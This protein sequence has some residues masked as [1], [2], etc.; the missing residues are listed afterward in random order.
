MSTIET[1]R[2]QLV[3]ASAVT[4]LVGQ[5]IYPQVLPPDMNT[6]PAVTLTLVSEVPVNSL[7][8]AAANRLKVARVQ[9]DVFAKTYREAHAAF[10][11]IDA[12][13]ADLSSPTLSAYGESSQDSYDDETQRHGVSG[14]Y[15]VS[16]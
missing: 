12:V 8:G 2:A 6:F 11:A 15:F 13:I 3:A 5:R 9:V 14:D 7:N 10:D 16:L 4:T 1:V